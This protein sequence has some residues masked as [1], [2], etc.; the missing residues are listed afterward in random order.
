MELEQGGDLWAL[1]RA[2][3]KAFAQ[4][5]VG[6]GI[7]KQQQ[8]VVRGKGLGAFGKGLEAYG[9]I[10]VKQRMDPSCGIMGAALTVGLE[11]KRQSICIRLVE[12]IEPKGPCH[13][14]V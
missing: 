13:R 6:V 3:S 11:E 5:G 2:M 8:L 14:A 4:S 9:R 1:G 7:G 10:G 12:C